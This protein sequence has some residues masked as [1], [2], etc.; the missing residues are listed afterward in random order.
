M[1]KQQDAPFIFKKTHIY[2]ILVSLCFLVY[3][4]SLNNAFVS[5]DIEGIVKN[6]S[7]AKFHWLDPTLFLNSLS[8]RVAKFNPL[9]YHLGSIIAHSIAT[10]MVFYFLKLFFGVEA[11][12]LATCLFAVHPIHTEAVSWLSGRGYIFMAI[13]ILGSYFLYNRATKEK[14]RL[15][16]YLF[17]FLLCS[18]YIVNNFSFYFLFPLLLV[19]SDFT[20]DRCKKNWIWWLPFFAVVI[21]RIVLA[22]GIIM[23]RVSSVIIEAGS[24]GASWANPIYNMAYSIFANAGLII[25]PAKLTLYHEPPVITRFLLNCELATL[26]ILLLALPFIFKR[27]RPLFFGIGLFILFLA[28]TYSP[29]MVSWLVAE[30]YIYFP[31]VA[32]CIFAAF[33]Y[34]KYIGKSEKARRKYA[35][36]LFIFIIAAYGVRTVARNEDWKRPE[37]LWRETALVSYLSPRSHNNLGDIYCQEGNI[38]GAISEFKKAIELKPDYGDAYY[39]LANV[40]QRAGN[41]PEA[42]KF[43]QSAISYK[44]EL[45]EAYFNLGVIYLNNTNQPDLAVQYLKKAAELRPDDANVIT[46]LNLALDKQR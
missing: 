42:I 7:I 33:C 31:S 20:L 44:P 37:R 25:W 23:S 14:F 41:I 6:P 22:K 21:L 36:A 3:A 8:Y 2:L 10:I 32:F 18:Y 17:C 34:E 16:P 39:N 30:R 27:A 11:S 24:K 13:F 29:V 35:L 43:Y 1:L 38:D 40:Y 12:F 4:N 46:A 26:A 28:P 19:L 9:P 5:D 45:F 15:L